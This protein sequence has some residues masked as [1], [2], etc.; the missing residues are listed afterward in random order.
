MRTNFGRMRSH[1]GLLLGALLLAGAASWLPACDQNRGQGEEA[2]EELRDEAGDV[3]DE[4]EDE[5]DDNT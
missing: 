4:V 2:V 3:K 1:G 5:V